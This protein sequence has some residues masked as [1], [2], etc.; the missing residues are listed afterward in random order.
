MQLP[1]QVT[2]RHVDPSPAVEA[3]VRELAE[4]LDHFYPRMTGC[5]VV[6]AGPPA[7]KHKGAPY[8]VR[9]DVIVPGEEIYVD[10]ERDLHE[11]HRDVYV[12]LRDAFDAVRRKL[13]DY[14]RRQ[15]GDVKHHEPPVRVG[16]ITELDSGA[17]FGRIE[18]EDGRLIYFH[19][20]SVHDAPFDSL[21]LGT[22]VKFE[23]EAGDLGPQAVAVRVL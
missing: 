19:R 9:I 7:H 3:R 14:A 21:A 10:S 2:F 4:R 22:R 17:G 6:I 11:E 18:S 12:A 5:H 16:V 8:S 23:D 1:I 15:R 20:N 13:E